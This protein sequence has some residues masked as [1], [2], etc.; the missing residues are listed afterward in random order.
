M[1]QPFISFREQ[2]ENGLLCYYICQ[3]AHPNYI[4]IVSVGQLLD[5]LAS[6]PVGGYNLYI[7]FN[8]CIQGSNLI[9][10]YNKVIEEIT[11]VMWQMAE[12]FL[13]QRVMADPKKYAKFKI[14]T[15]DSVGRK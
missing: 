6:A 11:G 4:G 2:N 12:W 15:N 3:K 5:S 9:P 14:I 7:N 8:G 10:S 13:N 1:K